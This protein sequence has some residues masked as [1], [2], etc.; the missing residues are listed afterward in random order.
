MV[1]VPSLKLHSKAGAEPPEITVG[2][3]IT[4]VASSPIQYFKFWLLIVVPESSEISIGKSK[5]AMNGGNPWVA[6]LPTKS[7]ASFVKITSAAFAVGFS[8]TSKKGAKP[9]GSS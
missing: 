3:V 8:I 1:L 5:E 4:N 7:I 2:S 6:N 9:S